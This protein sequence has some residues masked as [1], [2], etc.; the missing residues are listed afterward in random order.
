MSSKIPKPI[1]LTLPI[2]EYWSKEKE[3]MKFS[4]NKIWAA[5]PWS[6][7]LRQD[8]RTLWHREVEDL[9]EEN[10]L[11]PIDYPI[12]IEFIFHWKSR[13]L[14]CSNCWVMVKLIEDGLV[15]HWILEDDTNEFIRR[16]TIES[17]VID[18]KERK[19]MEEDFVIIKLI[20]YQ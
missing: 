3:K 15:E 20:P 14:D 9:I 5:W 6:Q 4:L 16:I 19:N 18:K 1:I 17:K 12:E 2:I 13:Y 10:N 11:K 8:K 7:W